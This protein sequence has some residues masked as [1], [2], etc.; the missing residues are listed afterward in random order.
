MI[1]NKQYVKKRNELLP[2]AKE[3]ADNV[4]GSKPK[5][6]E[7]RDTWA[8]RWSRAFSRRVDLLSK[9]FLLEDSIA[10]LGKD[11]A[12]KRAALRSKKDELAATIEAL[13]IREA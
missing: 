2:Q 10:D 4:V 12:E 6:D 1:S 8:T 3:Y 11:I 9:R 7:T 13:T 5:D